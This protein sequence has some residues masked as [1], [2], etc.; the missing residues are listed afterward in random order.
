M[1]TKRKPFKPIV[2]LEALTIIDHVEIIAVQAYDS[3]LSD[4]FRDLIRPN[5]QVVADFYSISENQAIFLSILITINLQTSSVDFSELAHYL[6][7]S[8]ITLAKYLSDIKILIDRQF[9]RATA[10]ENRKRR[11]QSLNSQEYYVNREFYQALLKGE[12]FIP[13]VKNAVNV[14]DL[15]KSVGQIIRGKEE[16]ENE[17]Q[18]YVE[19]NAVFKQNQHI[20][21]LQDLKPFN[22]DDQSLL[23]YLT[24]CSEFAFDP[25]GEF[26]FSKMIYFLFPDIQDNMAIRKQFL[27]ESHMLQKYDLLELEK[28][29]FRSDNLIFLT[30]KS[31][32]MLVGENKELFS[33]TKISTNKQ[34]EIIKSEEIIEKKLFYSEEEQKE[35]DFII[36]VL[37]P[38]NYKTMMKRLAEEGLPQGLCILFYGEAGTSKSA[39][40]LMVAKKTGRD[41]LNFKISEGKSMYYGESQKQIKKAFDF[42]RE[43]VEKSTV[44]PIFLL[45]EADGLLTKRKRSDFNQGVMQTENAIQTI[46]LNE[47]ENLSGCLIASTNLQENFDPSFYRRFLIKKSFKKLSAQIM[48]KVWENKLPWLRPS[49][50]E[51]LSKYEITGAI[52]ENVQ[53]KLVLQ[54]ALYGG[55]RQNLDQIIKYLEEENVNKPLES[56]KIGFVK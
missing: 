10:E 14:F 39:L 56:S 34:F 25:N 12:K 7:I 55:E 35:I 49:D 22:L 18:L 3:G 21:F 26:D 33:R 45:N 31:W 1:S 44:A 42:Y 16:L 28:G 36:D 27:K 48:Y 17:N 5:A 51:I 8:C 23:I 9:V 38:E 6:D 41:V 40:S 54:R 52:V 11:R 47:I 15:L 32:G 30:E 37:Q 43:I 2:N 20:Q 19:I 4:D 24:V 29:S 50:L 13:L 53:R 46:L